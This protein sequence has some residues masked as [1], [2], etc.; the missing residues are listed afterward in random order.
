MNQKELLEKFKKEVYEDDD[1]LME[2]EF[3]H[4]ENEPTKV[5]SF[6]VEY[7]GEHNVLYDEGSVY[8][9]KVYRIN[10]EIFVDSISSNSWCD[11]YESSG[12]TPGE[13]VN[14]ITYRSK[15]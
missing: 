10:G 4:S 6:I 3:I 14:I 1:L 9:D 12:L 2:F 13:E 15:Q 5:G 7:L 8:Y 11:Y